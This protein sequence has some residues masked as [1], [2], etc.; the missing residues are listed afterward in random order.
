MASVTN[1]PERMLRL[2]LKVY[3]QAS[4]SAAE[5]HEFAVNDHVAK[6]AKIH[7]KHGI[8]MYQQVRLTPHLSHSSLTPSTIEWTI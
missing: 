8:E 1:R 2:S 4:K 5:A 3:H 6:A 7:A